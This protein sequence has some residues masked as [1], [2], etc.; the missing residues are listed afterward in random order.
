MGQLHEILYYCTLCLHLSNLGFE[1]VVDQLNFTCNLCI[2]D[3][4]REPEIQRNLYFPEHFSQQG[5]IPFDYRLLPFLRK[6]IEEEIE[7]AYEMTGPEESCL[8]GGLGLIGQSL[9]DFRVQFS[10]LFRELYAYE[11]DVKAV[12]EKQKSEILQKLD[13]KV[14]EFLKESMTNLLEKDIGFEKRNE[15]MNRIVE[16]VRFKQREAKNSIEDLARNEMMQIIEPYS[17][18]IKNTYDR[19]EKFRS[20]RPGENNSFM[21]LYS[22]VD[23]SLN[24]FESNIALGKVP[25]ESP[26]FQESFQKFNVTLEI[27]K[28]ST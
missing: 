26:R 13:Q 6:T 17:I 12:Y 10:N 8:Y 11:R 5:E 20:F 19:M 7:Y 27:E 1:D 16:T 21:D 23:D 9:A 25:D 28:L 2:N 22:L 3:L 14:E 24:I 15:K 4:V 18:M